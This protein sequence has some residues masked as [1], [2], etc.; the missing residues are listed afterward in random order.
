MDDLNKPVRPIKAEEEEKLRVQRIENYKHYIDNSYTPLP[1]KP[2]KNKRSFFIA[3]LNLVRK[4]FNTFVPEKAGVSG[5]LRVDTLWQDL[6]DIRVFLIMI[7]D[8]DPTNDLKFAEK[9][10]EAWR[11]IL[12][13]FLHRGNQ[14]A[15]SKVDIKMTKDLIQ[16]INHYPQGESH[17]LGFYL[18]KYGDEDWYPAPFFKF[19]HQL[20]KEYF[21]QGKNS[22]LDLWISTINEILDAAARS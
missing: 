8:E 5:V 4:F 2:S 6:K 15:P 20:H 17:S 22:A 14:P 9:F 12:D 1:E 13:H 3:S 11:R 10:S 19:L 16:A 21:T 18:K 7:R